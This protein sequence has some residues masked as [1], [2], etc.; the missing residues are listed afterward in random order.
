M[1]KSVQLLGAQAARLRQAGVWRIGVNVTGI[2]PRFHPL[3]NPSP[4]QGEGLP[5]PLPPLWTLMGKGGLVIR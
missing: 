1:G 5:A 3:P 2:P 4:I